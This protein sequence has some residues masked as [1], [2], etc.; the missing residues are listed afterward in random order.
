[1]DFPITYFERNLV[2][3]VRREAWAAYRLEPWHYEHLGHDQRLGLLQRLSRLFWQLEDYEGHLCIIP[4]RH[5]VRS[6]L[7][8]LTG[9]LDGPLAE[10]GRRYATGAAE[11][12]ER[13]FGPEGHEYSYYVL[14]RLPK[15]PPMPAD[16]KSWARSLYREPVRLVEELFGV[17]PFEVL[18]Y[19]LQACLDREEMVMQR[20]SQV[21]RATRLTERDVEWLV[22]RAFFRGIGEPPLREGWRPDAWVVP[23]PGGR[24]ALRPSRPEVLTL[25]EG[26]L[27][28][29]HPRRIG[30]TQVHGGAEVTAWQ[31]FAVL[32][33]LPDELPFPGA[34]WIYG[35]QDLPFPVEVHLRWA[36]L[37]YREALGIVRRKKLEIA[38]QDRHTRRAGEDAP[39]ALLEAQDQALVLE[40]DL[41]QRKFPTLLAS[42]AFAVSA[43]EP[44]VLVERLGHLKGHLCALQCSVEV[45]AGDQLKLFLDCLPGAPRRARDYIHRL[46]PEVVAAGMP[47]CTKALGDGEGPYVGRTGALGQPV[48]LD[49]AR[50]PRIN[51]SAS[52]AFIGSLGGGKSFT[53]NLVTYLSVITGGARAL[54]L[55]P[56]GERSGWTSLL[57]ELAGHLNLV[58]LGPHPRHAGRLDPFVIFRS[59]GEAGRQEATNLAVSLLSFLCR[60]RPGDPAFVAILEAVEAVREHPAP[61]LHQVVE[62]LSGAAERR[63]EVAGLGP[64][65]RALTDLAYAGLLFGRGDE[66]TIDTNFPLNILQL[67]HLT[68]P[69]PGRP[70][71]DYTL[72]ETLSVALL[73]AV[74]AFAA[75]FT[76]RDR[77]VF[78][79]VLLD[80][81]WAVM[82]SGQGRALVTHL[83]RTGRAMNTAV[84]LVTQ[85]T[86]DLLDET[87]R[88]QLGVKFLFR[89]DDSGEVARSLDLLNLDQSDENIATLRGLQTGEALFQDLDG[90]VGVMRI[91]PVYEHLLAAFDTRPQA[92]AAHGGWGE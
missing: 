8:Q 53:A 28:L 35:L 46:P 79:V 25:A 57:P 64:Y 51:R 91:D 70:R 55:D 11:Y 30:V 1:M 90:R 5:G 85:S 77:A 6:H 7:D 50:P 9:R 42:M 47:L 89:S 38:D 24:Q 48:Y 61:G 54:V 58:T 68:L 72:E 88:N 21:V 2:F 52:A 45:P 32:A 23:R 27:D 75:W 62:Y 36:S 44:R 14:V 66:E 59:L 92:L 15:P 18:D 80:E 78:K 43:A 67:Q 3:N 87:V 4:R 31:G 74:T 17:S 86:A 33:E 34:E 22:R 56:K 13:L 39:L 12:L 41:K 60:A 37:P 29:R 83:L 20:L 26:E 10:V 65:L 40:H 76:R 81:A 82:A 84:Y 69:P 19:E 63:P 71:D 16:L 73:H 49:P